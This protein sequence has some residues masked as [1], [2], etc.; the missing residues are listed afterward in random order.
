M[1]FTELLKKRA[2]IR[3]Y[4]DKPVPKEQLLAL[5]EAGIRAPNACNYQSWH[6]YAVCEK[7][8]IAAFHPDIANIP[9]V[10]NIPLIIVV[11]IKETVAR[12]LEQRFGAQGRMF[13]YQDAAGA[14]NHILLKAADLGLGGCWIGPMNPEKCKRHLSIAEDHTPVAI[15]TIGTPAADPPLRDR[16][17]LSEAVTFVGDSVSENFI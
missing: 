14:I 9:W 6:F 17:P 10:A 11:C 5:L 3:S 12:R 15:L 16:K 8:T 13:A 7:K 1:E 2:S 4:K